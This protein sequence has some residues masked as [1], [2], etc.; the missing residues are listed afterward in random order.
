MNT[1]K[2]DQS[3]VQDIS[4][5]PDTA[6]IAEAIIAMGQSLQ[7]NVIAEGVETEEQLALIRS[8]KCDELQG[9]LFS[10]PVASED[11][12]ALLVEGASMTLV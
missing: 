3:F 7:L 9:Y 11:A 6:T 8:L 12:T 2:I 10:K 5:D 4:S 1:L